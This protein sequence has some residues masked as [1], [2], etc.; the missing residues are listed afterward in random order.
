M[1][2]PAPAHPVQAPLMR[3]LLASGRHLILS[4]VLLATLAAVSVANPAFASRANLL[5]LLVQAAPTIIVGCA[6]TL[7][8]LTGEIDISVGS[9]LG[10]LAA[11]MGVLASPQR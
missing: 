8:V 4:A 7:V 9:L 2:P 6:M 1:P 10:L 11:L 3:L 5:D